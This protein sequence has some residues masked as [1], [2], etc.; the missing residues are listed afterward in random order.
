MEKVGIMG[1]T[2][3]PVHLSHLS[4]AARAYNQLKLDRV[5]F[6][7]SKNPAYKSRK[8]LAD[9]KD[10]SEMIKLAIKDYPYFEFSDF[11]LKREGNTYTADTLTM[12]KELN[13]DTEYYFILGG[14]SLDYFE[15]WNRPEVILKNCVIVC[16]PR[17][18]DPSYCDGKLNFNEGKK[19][20]FLRELFTE[21]ENGKPVFVPRIIMLPPVLMDIS[22]TI[23]RK[24]VKCGRNIG[25]FVTKEV[26]DYIEE[27]NLYKTDFF[28]NAK[29]V[30][31]SVLKPKRYDHSLRVADCAFELALC[32]GYDPEKAYTAGLLHD[33]AKYLNDNEILEEA[34][35][36]GIE[37]SDVERRQAL[38][39]LHS[40]VGAYWVR[41][42]YGI[43]DEEIFGAV[44][45]HTTGRPDM[46]MLEKI[47]YLS[48]ILEPGRDIPYTPSLDCIRA[49]ATYD[50]DL[51]CYHILE[52]VVPYLLENYKD[53]VC[54]TTVDTYYYYKD[55]YQ[56]NRQ[57]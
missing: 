22:S 1:G 41:D 53:N 20:G 45:Y 8:E 37:V 3:N 2:F 6:M 47:I 9:E 51:A 27:N 56:K 19:A 48:D 21:Y 57:E 33:C 50:P 43:D 52:N 38:N 28:E 18:V 44:Y 11:E 23:I 46:N 4:I 13:P 35:K 16:A 7:P 25:G 29:K 55:L 26:S 40:K 49:E 17:P 24:T 54:M 12:L 34:E 5:L 36:L 10:R 42:K 15:K 31:K 30:L 39:L 14:D 32:L